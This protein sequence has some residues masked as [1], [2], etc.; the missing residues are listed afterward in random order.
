MMLQN[1]TSRGNFI[2]LDRGAFDLMQVVQT[3][4][5]KTLTTVIRRPMPVAVKATFHYTIQV[6]E[7]QTWS[8][9]WSQTC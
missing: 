2:F 7:S 4:S 3:T 8:A 5:Y 9:T 1:T 6:A